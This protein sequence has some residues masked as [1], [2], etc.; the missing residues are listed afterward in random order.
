MVENFNKCNKCGKTWRRRT[1]EEFKVFLE[2]LK[3]EMQVTKEGCDI[4]GFAMYFHTIHN[5][6]GEVQYFHEKEVI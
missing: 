4:F 2:D 1:Q 3:N 6:G 5:C